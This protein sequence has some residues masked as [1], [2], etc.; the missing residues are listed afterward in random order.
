MKYNNNNDD[1]DDDNNKRKKSTRSSL[2]MY[3]KRKYYK[4]CTKG[5]E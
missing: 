4:S 5:K 2:E 1:D 3:C